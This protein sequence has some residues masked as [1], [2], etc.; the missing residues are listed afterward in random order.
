LEDMFTWCTA[1]ASSDDP[2][3]LQVRQ[4]RLLRA[5]SAIAKSTVTAVD[6]LLVFAACV[7]RCSH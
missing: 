7:M 3:V 1:P 4:T 6:R 2:A 5:V